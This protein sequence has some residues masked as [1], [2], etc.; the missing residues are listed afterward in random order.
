MFIAVLATAAKKRT[1]VDILPQITD[2]KACA[3]AQRK[4]FIC[5]EAALLS[6]QDNRHGMCGKRNKLDSCLNI[7]PKTLVAQIHIFRKVA[8][9]KFTAQ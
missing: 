9:I 8:G 4:A 6:P 7:S 2:K 5:D 3:W 1:R